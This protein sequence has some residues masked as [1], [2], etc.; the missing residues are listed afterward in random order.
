[1]A[2]Q[3]R[4]V[5]G[6]RVKGVVRTRKGMSQNVLR[7]TLMFAL[8]IV[9]RRSFR[10]FGGATGSESASVC[11]NQASRLSEISAN[12]F[13]RVLAALALTRIVRSS[14]SIF[15]NGVC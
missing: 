15:S 7:P 8:A 10:R 1:M 4:G 13:F 3:H 5:S 6:I 9:S 11:A 12:R 2:E 14:K